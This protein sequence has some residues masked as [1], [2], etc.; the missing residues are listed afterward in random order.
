MKTSKQNFLEPIEYLENERVLWEGGASERSFWAQFVED[1]K[2]WTI[3]LDKVIAIT[4]TQCMIEKLSGLYS[5]ELICSGWS[6]HK[7][8]FGILYN[9]NQIKFLNTDEK[10]FSRLVNEWLPKDNLQQIKGT[11]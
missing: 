11:K 4:T 1:F 8:A 5:I 9:P 6:H 10:V 7:N 3:D 2:K